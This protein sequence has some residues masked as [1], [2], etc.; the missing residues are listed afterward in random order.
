[1]ACLK[2]SEHAGNYLPCSG[3]ACILPSCAQFLS[4]IAPVESLCRLLSKSREIHTSPGRGSIVYGSF[5]LAPLVLLQEYW[6][7]LMIGLGLML[8]VLAFFYQRQQFLRR[9]TEL[10][11]GLKQSMNRSLGAQL[12]PH[13]LYN[14]LN[15]IN[16]SIMKGNTDE[17]MRIVGEF[18]KLMRVVFNNSRKNLVSVKEELE[19]VRS[20][21]DLELSRLENGFEFETSC[22]VGSEN[23][24]IP[25]L[26]IQPLVENSIWHGLS[27][28]DYRGKV[29][30]S[31]TLRD[32]VV[33]VRVKDNGKGF[34]ETAISKITSNRAT[35][36]GVLFE[37]MTLLKALY[38]PTVSMKIHS[39]KK[40][41]P[42]TEVVI[43]FPQ[44][45]TPHE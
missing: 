41:N 21:V 14:V 38:G 37:R 22:S 16:G 5:S 17:S 3:N 33:E 9:T 2:N 27:N 24:L 34:S 8:M 29:V 19:A 23:L 25:A 31:V 26:F 44:I 4:E 35:A 10:E 20:Y 11:Y 36:L 18:S 30:L 40:V 1:M 45:L 7:V 43:T 6:A 32:S 13:F 39:D 28:V 42:Y 15:T 12:T